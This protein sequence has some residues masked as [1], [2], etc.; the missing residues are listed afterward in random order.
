MTTLHED[1]LKLQELLSVPE[2][3]TQHD[4]AKDASGR[5]VLARSHSAV[6]WCLL[7]AAQKVAEHESGRL[8]DKLIEHPGLNGGSVTHF[9]DSI[10]HPHLLAFLEEFVESTK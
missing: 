7:G 10:D 3:W 4:M 6:C 1:A 5:C 9:N 8:L 2:R